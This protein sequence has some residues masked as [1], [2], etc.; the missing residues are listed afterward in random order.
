V[1]VQLVGEFDIASVPCVREQL[2]ALPLSGIEH[3]VL[4]LQG[5]SF[6]SASGIRM[7]VTGTGWADGSPQVHLVGVVGNEPLRR[8]LALAE[9]PPDVLRHVA[10]GDVLDELAQDDADGT[11]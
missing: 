8:V 11:S 5:V 7:L 9:V 6:L 3:V 2:G 10:S 4:D 1:V